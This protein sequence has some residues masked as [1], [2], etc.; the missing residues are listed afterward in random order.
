MQDYSSSLGG[1]GDIPHDR[2]IDGHAW[3]QSLGSNA[4]R[5]PPARPGFS[6][7]AEA[8]PEYLHFPIPG[9]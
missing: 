9:A 6:S 1:F 3:L 7:I 2:C 8:L 5:K 4:L